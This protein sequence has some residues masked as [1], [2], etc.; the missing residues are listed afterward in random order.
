MS[1][2]DQN[3]TTSGTVGGGA[4]AV[5]AGLRNYMMRI[6]NYMAGGVGLTAVVAWL[7]Y[8]LTGPELLQNPVM[9]VFILAPL[10]LVFF[11]GAR[12]NTLSV[13]TARLL[14]FLYAALVGVSLSTLFHIYTNASIT[15]VFVIAAATFGALSIFGYTTRRDLSGLGTF[16]FMGLIGIIIAS[17]VNLFLRST[18]LDWLVSIVGVGVF[19]GLTAYD[20]QRIKAMYDSR[21][22]ETSA[23]RKSVISALS[24]YLNF[25]NLFMMMLRLAGGRR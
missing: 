11:I 12:I 18:G 13:S 23:G 24:L 19:A 21:D 17:L 9:W 6:Y 10:A 5:D 3:V 16:L 8:Q 15:R 25:I 2:F 7:T 22:D 20:T 4:T 14:F 1:N